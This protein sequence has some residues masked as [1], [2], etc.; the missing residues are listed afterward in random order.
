[1]NPIK[2]EQQDFDKGPNSAEKMNWVGNR[3]MQWP[4]L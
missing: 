3:N 1:M 4:N 2:L